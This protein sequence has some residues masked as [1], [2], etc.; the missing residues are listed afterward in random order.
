[1]TGLSCCYRFSSGSALVPSTDT[2]RRHQPASP[3]AE[4]VSVAPS[5]DNKASR[6]GISSTR[7]AAVSHPGLSGLSVDQ[8]ARLAPTVLFYRVRPARICALRHYLSIFDALTQRQRHLKPRCS[9]HHAASS[10]FFQLY[11]LQARGASDGAGRHGHGTDMSESGCRRLF[12]SANLMLGVHTP[13]RRRAPGIA[14]QP[15]HRYAAN[16]LPG[17]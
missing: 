17:L 8:S 12:A 3:A 2:V 9:S 13:R 6:I 4:P 11:H 16:I 7:R 10:V 14:L 5:P 1:M 15:L